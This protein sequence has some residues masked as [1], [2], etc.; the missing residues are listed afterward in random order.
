MSIV[1]FL[2][3]AKCDWSI[4]NIQERNR[5]FQL[6]TPLSS[7]RRLIDLVFPPRLLPCHRVP[8]SKVCIVPSYISFLLPMFAR[9]TSSSL[10]LRHL[11]DG[12]HRN[13]VGLV[14]GR[15]LVSPSRHIF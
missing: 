9:A 5:N 2:S 13:G 15:G 7:P 14:I 10:L 4:Q 6:Y 1:S 11:L 3:V 8:S 12:L